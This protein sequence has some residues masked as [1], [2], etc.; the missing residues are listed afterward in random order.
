MA[1]VF[2]QK[3]AILVVFLAKNGRHYEIFENFE[4]V[5]HTISQAQFYADLVKILGSIHDFGP[6]F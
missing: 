1:A 3:T 6:R 4:N 5:L 2:N